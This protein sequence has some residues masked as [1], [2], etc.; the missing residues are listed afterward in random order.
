MK[1][2]I[3][4]ILG[5]LLIMFSVQNTSFAQKIYFCE[6]VKTSTG[7]PIGEGTTFNIKSS[8][9]WLYVL[10]HSGKA[11]DCT[12]VKIKYYL[13]GKLEDSYDLNIEPDWDRFWD[14]VTFY[15]AGNY[16]V[17]VYDCNGKKIT[18]GSLKIK[19]RK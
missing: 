5:S 9:G 8:G 11:L 4:T 13:N 7:M 1:H 12:K 6:D 18:S 16:D 10:I 19:F 14:K 15:K 17:Y 2:L 3:I